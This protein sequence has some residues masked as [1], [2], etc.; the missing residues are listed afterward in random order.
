MEDIVLQHIQDK[1]LELIRTWRSSKG[2]NKFMYTTISPTI[3]EQAQWFN[4]INNDNSSE[5]WVVSYN[6]IPVGVANIS[7]IDLINK[8][9][10]W[11]FYL[12]DTSI[13]GKGIGSKIEY[14]TIEYVFN[15]L[16][17]NKLTCEVFNFNESVIKMHEKFGFRR[18]AY[19]RNHIYKEN[20]PYDVVGLGLLKTDWDN[21][22]TSIKNKIYG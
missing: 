3:E 22:K 14:K 15:D 6:N 20:A 17:L 8:K 19:Y 5:Y 4:E 16:G 1:D 21:I 7:N 2:V 13:R 10:E 12:G 9:C 11:A 18:E